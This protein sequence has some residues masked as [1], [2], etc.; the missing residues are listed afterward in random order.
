M[1][2]IEK[3]GSASTFHIQSFAPSHDPYPVRPAAKPAVANP[4]CLGLFAFATTSLILS[5][6]NTNARNIQNGDLIVGM[7]LFSG[8]LA[9]FVAGMWD[10]PRG[11]MFGASAFGMYGAFWMSYAVILFPGSGVAAAYRENP[12]ELENAIAIFLAA[13]FIVTVFFWIATLRKCIA[14]VVTFGFLAITF[15]VLS[16]AHFTGNKDV[17]RAGGVIGIF[18]SFMAYY[19]G[20]SELLA[21]EDRPVITLP[22]GVF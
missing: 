5:L 10:F 21:S 18:T 6:Y 13:W 3:A 14:F 4:S 7:S 19:I 16:A 15:M 20:L 22:L 8:G 17:G 2:D 9:Q 1:N 12:K 11:D